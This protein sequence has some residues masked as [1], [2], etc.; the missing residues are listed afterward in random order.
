MR[1]EIKR[2]IRKRKKRKAKK[3]F[4]NSNLE[5]N[6]YKRI[7]H[8]HVRKSAGTSVNAAFWELGNLT[9]KKL[10]REPIAIAKQKVFVRNSKDLIEEGFFHYAN[11]HTPFWN[12]KIPKET[13]TFCL[14]R[15][16]YERLLSL[17]KYHKWVEEMPDEAKK[18]DPYFESIKKNSHWVGNSFS[19]YLDNLPKKN[20]MNQLYMFS[21]TYNVKEALQNVDEL[22]AVYF[23]NN[24]NETINSLSKGLSLNL[25]V[26]NERRMSRRVSINI[27]DAEKVKAINYL[28][29]EYEFYVI[30]KN[31][32][33]LK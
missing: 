14:F 17:Y 7:Y 6:G 25:T 10:K 27:S 22:T 5:F 8:F 9:L 12:I 4:E 18:T 31:R 32:F 19:D 3:V 33:E 13:F 30:L 1:T 2:Y 29:D 28:K 16:P 24:F 21:E 23:Q 26:K 15:D 20:L 11:S